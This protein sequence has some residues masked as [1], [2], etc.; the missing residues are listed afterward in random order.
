MATLVEKFME[1]VEKNGLYILAAQVR[2]GGEVA[3]EW[4][5][6]EAKPRFEGFSI[7]KT[8]VGIGAGIAIEEGLITMDERII[9][10]FPEAGYNVTNE[11]ALSITVRDLLTMTSGLSETMFWRDGY[12]RKHVHDWIRFF[13]KE[14]RFDNRPGTT[15]LYNNA[16]PYM[17]GCLIEKKCGQNLREYLRYRFFEPTG[18]HNVEWTSCPM[19]HT[20]ASNALQVN[21]DELGQIG[22]LLANGGE[23]NGKRIVSEAFVKEMLTPYSETGEYIPSDSPVRAG[24]GYNTWIDGLNH[25]AFMWGIFG[26]YCVILPEKNA[27]ITVMGLD[28]ADGGSN[29]V[30]FTSPV[31]KLIWEDLVTQV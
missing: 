17:L 7:S 28:P 18:I 30:Y 15:F 1:D 29:G 8:V 23:Y 26:H 14:G 9:D 12:E 20:I 19:G 24:Y 31:R 3:E 13:Y 27:V 6:F 16:N 5:R 25:A 4:S 11:N 22:Q 2:K 10:S 21:V